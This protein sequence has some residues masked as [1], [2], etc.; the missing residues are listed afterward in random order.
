MTTTN[1][2]QKSIRIHSLDELRGFALLGILIMNIISFSNIGIGYMNPNLGAGIEGYNKWFHGFSF[3]FADMRFMSIFSM[4][5][6]AGLI[7]FCK[8]IAAK[9]KSEKAFHYRRMFF[10]LLFGFIHAYLIWM[11]DILVMYAI[12]GSIVFLMR[13]WKVKTQLI[14]AGIFFCIP[15]LF[16]LS[17]Y[18]FTPQAMLEEIFAFWNPSSEELNKEL[19]A[20][21][22]S[23][24]D[25]LP[26]RISAAIGLQTK[27]FILEQLWRILAMMLIGMV[28]F[29]KGI[30]SA[31]KSKSY[32][33]KMASLGLI[34]G[35]LI[36]ATAL[37][38]AYGKN[39]DGIWFMNIGHYYNYIASLCMALG[40]IGLI[41]LWSKSTIFEKLKNR[42][43]AAGRMAFTNYILSSVICTFIF[44]GHG[45]GY[46]GYLDRMEQWII[47]LIVWAIILI[48]SPILLNK[49]RQGP[50]EYAWRRLTYLGSYKE[51]VPS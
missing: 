8:N 6:G 30:L 5:F 25:Q 9:N 18:F 49:Y 38:R 23:Y 32:Y 41:M 34:I 27:L 51:K 14:V 7:L 48:I 42:F 45:L 39:W 50:L 20:Y 2:N 10:L 22:S 46:F 26:M 4:L 35:L 3:L 13:N 36:S 31:E 1:A 15:I 24:M 28:L 43:A 19:A 44:Y 37:Y 17:T 16:S 11:G 47:I 12:C 40:Y 33:I 29:K 21:R